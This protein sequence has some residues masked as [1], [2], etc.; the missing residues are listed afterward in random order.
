MKIPRF[1]FPEGKQFAFTIL[2]DTDVAT[3]ANVEP[4]YALLKECGFRTTK[5]VW[6]MSWTGSSSNFASSETLEDPAYLQFVRDLAQAGFE[7]ASHGATMES[8][9]RAF[10]QEAISRFSSLLGAVP[11][12]YANHSLNKENVYW[13]HGRIDNPLLKQVYRH[14]IQTDDEHYQGHIEESAWW[15][16][17]LCKKH[18]T[19][20]RN[21]TYNNLNVL[22]ANPSMPYHDPRRPYVN[23]WF[24]AAD[25]E[26]CDE[27]A[28]RVTKERIDELEAEGGVCILATHLGKRYMQDGRV[29]RRFEATVRYL[30]TKPG[31]YVPVGELLDWLRL[32]RAGGA[33]LP[34]GEWTAMQWRWARDLVARKLGW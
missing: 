33:E 13:G 6:P 24:S 2:D 30:A 22:R 28:R 4:V 19:Y 9:T 15:W 26:D 31:W 20:V 16:G 8:S 32:S 12:V 21:L 1:P 5:T 3:V 18:H 23:W 29:D 10:T 7:I 11:R 34:P 14:V 25:A 17:D 27:F